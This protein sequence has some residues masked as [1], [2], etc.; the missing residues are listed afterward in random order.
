[1]TIT[2][3]DLGVPLLVGLSRKSTVGKITGRP[4]EERLAGSLAMALLALQG[5]ARIL[6][7]HDVRETLDVVRV[8]QAYS[9]QS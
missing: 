3:E 7:V 5:G 2:F 9:S 1:M 6:R 8:W 4:V